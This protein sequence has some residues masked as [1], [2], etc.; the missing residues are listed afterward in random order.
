MTTIQHSNVFDYIILGGGIAGLYSA[1]SILKKNKKANILILE[2][3]ANVGGRVF[4]FKNK[5]MTVEAGAGRF[6]SEQP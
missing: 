5:H 4:T 6:H 1:Y 2:K 3:H